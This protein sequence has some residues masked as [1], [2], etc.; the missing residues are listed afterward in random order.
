MIRSYEDLDVYKISHDL[1]I[2]IHRMTMVL[3]KFELFEE[4][5]QIRRSA[6][7]IPANIVEG[8][9]RRRYLTEYIRYLVFAHG[10]CNETKEHLNILFESG[11]WKDTKG[12]E[13]LKQKYDKLGRMLNKLISV[14][15]NYRDFKPIT[16]NSQPTTVVP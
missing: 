6:K 15:E 14:V 16:H 10:S 4:G 8:F 12:Y 3:P 1:S 2:E 11:S 9:S 5:S 7:A 13:D